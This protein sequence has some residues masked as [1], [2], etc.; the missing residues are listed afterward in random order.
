M[1][2]EKLRLLC[3]FT[4]WGDHQIVYQLGSEQEVEGVFGTT[5]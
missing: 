3:I 1:L 2:F 4:S 5:A